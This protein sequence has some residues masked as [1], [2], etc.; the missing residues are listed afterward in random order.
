MPGSATL[1]LEQQV[2]G[3]TLGFAA[4]AMP[5]IFVGLC[6]TAPTSTQGGTEVAGGAYS[7]QGAGF[8]LI[9]TPPNIAANTDSVEYLP[10]TAPWG[11]V[12]WFELWDSSTMGNRLYWGPLVDPTDGVT[13][14]SRTITVDD[15]MRFSAGVLQVQAL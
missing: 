13:P 6:T 10:A 4:M 11:T 7:R 14:I 5:S 9:A 15:I 8:A 3:H 2:L 12:G 1:W